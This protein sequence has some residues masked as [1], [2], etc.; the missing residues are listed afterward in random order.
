M[1]DNKIES[2]L[3]C[4]NNFI[5][6]ISSN[7]NDIFYPK[8]KGLSQITLKG[9]LIF[10]DNSILLMGIFRLK[11]VD[12]QLIINVIT[13]LN[14]TSANL[15]VLIN[16]NWL[17]IKNL[18]SNY[19][20]MYNKIAFGYDEVPN[21]L[22]KSIIDSVN[23]SELNVDDSKMFLIPYKRKIN[24]LYDTESNTMENLYCRFEYILKIQ[25]KTKNMFSFNICRCLSSELNENN[26]IEN[27]RFDDIEV[28]KSN[29]LSLDKL[30]S[31]VK[32]LYYY[33]EIIN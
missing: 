22:I 29:T 5:E 31:F 2:P 4:F 28:I 15:F 27:L 1:I 25:K 20:M 11:L 13:P 12:N 30:E 17:T 18:L 24:H 16:D 10:E 8:T 23:N 26:S 3:S 6:K 32:Q 14:K 9:Q 19:I 21:S 33:G 7:F